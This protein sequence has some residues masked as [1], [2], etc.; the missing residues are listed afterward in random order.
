MNC[1]AGRLLMLNDKLVGC[2]PRTE[3]HFPSVNPY[4]KKSNWIESDH[5]LLQHLLFTLFQSS[6]IILY[7]FHTYLYFFFWR[8]V[9]RE[10]RSLTIPDRE[11]FLDAASA[12]WKYNQTEGQ[13]KFGPKFTSIGTSSGSDIAFLKPHHTLH[14]LH[15]YHSYHTCSFVESR[16][17]AV[18]AAT[19]LFIPSL[20]HVHSHCLLQDLPSDFIIFIHPLSFF[21]CSRGNEVGGCEQI[22]LHAPHVPPLTSTPTYLILRPLCNLQRYSLLTTQRLQTIICAIS[23]TMAQDFS[24]II[25]HSPTPS[26]WVR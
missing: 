25:S 4:R 23:F 5:S 22:L 16:F 19:H 7:M 14:P 8:F 24:H 6:Y 13:A 15:S 9:K 10:I 1:C 20:P 12:L 3:K 11:R 21:A 26:R 2:F 17:W 18:Y